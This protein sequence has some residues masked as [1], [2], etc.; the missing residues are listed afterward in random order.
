M[1]L[2]PQRWFRVD[3]GAAKL[4]I[5]RRLSEHST[6]AQNIAL[7]LSPIQILLMY[8]ASLGR[9]ATLQGSK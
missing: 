7:N 9:A 1:R 8:F 4:Q 5:K 2:S 3:I 6:L